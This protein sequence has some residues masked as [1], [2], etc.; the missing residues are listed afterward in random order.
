MDL[1]EKAAEGEQRFT[2]RSLAAREAAWRAARNPGG[3]SLTHCL[4]CGDEIPAARRQAI[5][6]CE[7][8]AECQQDHER[9][10]TIKR[11]TGR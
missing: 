1:A 9:R 10:E 5:P 2:D 7:R 4:D 8:C 11:R 3:A 6:A